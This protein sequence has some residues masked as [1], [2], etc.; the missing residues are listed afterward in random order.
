MLVPQKIIHS[1]F[2]LFQLHI[3]HNV[4][5]DKKTDMTEKVRIWKCAVMILFNA[6]VIFTW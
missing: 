4:E 2:M 6:V 3:L 5:S 1:V